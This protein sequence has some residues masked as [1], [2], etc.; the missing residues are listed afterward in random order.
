MCAINQAAYGHAAP[1]ATWLYYV[2]DAEPPAM[3]WARPDSAASISTGLASRRTMAADGAAKMR[4]RGGIELAT[5]KARL[6]TPPAFR[7]ALLALARN[8]R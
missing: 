7:D 2:G 5:H 8:C 4:R 3:S 1:K 6:A